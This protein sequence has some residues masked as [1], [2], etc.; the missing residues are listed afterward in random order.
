MEL[1]PYQADALN[2]AHQAGERWIYADAAGTGKTPTTVVWLDSVLPAGTVGLVAAPDSVVEQWVAQLGLWTGRQAVDLRGS[3]EARKRARSG[4]SVDSVGVLNLDL[5][6]RDQDE[7]LKL[8]IGALVIDEAHRLKG[9]STQVA[10]AA[11]RLAKVAPFEATLTG[12][13]LLN[14][15]EELWIQLHMAKPKL[16]TSFWRWAREHF[17]VELTTHHGKLQNPVPDIVGLKPGH[18][19]M[20]RAEAGSVMISRSIDE[21]LPGLPPVENVIVPVQL[22]EYERKL[23]NDIK[24]RGWGRHGD[25]V[26]RT[27]SKVSRMLRMRQISSAWGGILHNGDMMLST[28]DEPGAKITAAVEL[29]RGSSEPVVV[30]A[31]FKWTTSV[32]HEMLPGSVTYTGAES[33]KERAHA[34]QQFAS[35]DSPIIIGTIAALGEGVDG[36][37]VAHRMVRLDRDWTPAR[38]EQVIGRIRRSGQKAER[39]LV[40]DVVAEDTI[41]QYVAEALR[42]K[43]DVIDAI[44]A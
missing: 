28:A 12:T 31:A 29:I 14:T 9:R 10:L 3:P 23:Y 43:E 26:V 39:L 20:I 21:L 25:S 44:L 35:G 8:P 6:R 1:R 17:Y 11:R 33:K 5:L 37:Q 42:N 41:D 2:F 15:A 18:D 24:R 27:K 38:N 36:L 13:P 40:V 34:V 4:L 16:Y 30:L 7:L 32:L 19:E 22:G